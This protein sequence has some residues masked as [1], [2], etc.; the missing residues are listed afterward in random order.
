MRTLESHNVLPL[1]VNMVRYRLMTVYS[2]ATST[3]FFLKTMYAAK[4]DFCFFDTKWHEY[5]RLAIFVT[6]FVFFFSKITIWMVMFFFKYIY[7]LNGDK[8]M[9]E[10]K[11]GRVLRLV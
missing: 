3:L 4:V 10:S 9:S 5:V 1:F 11:L 7:T 6:I 2:S 8:N